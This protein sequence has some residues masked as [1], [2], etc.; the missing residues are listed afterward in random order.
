M[1]N[2]SIA[3]PTA[4]ALTAMALMLVLVDAAAAKSARASSS[5]VKAATAKLEPIV[6]DH[7]G[8]TRPLPKPRRKPICAGWAC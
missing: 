8:Q 7:R 5:T 6:R 4:I 2:K 3:P 1:T